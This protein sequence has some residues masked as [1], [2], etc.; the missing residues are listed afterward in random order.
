MTRREDDAKRKAGVAMIKDFP[1]QMFVESS[2][3][4]IEK[5]LCGLSR[6]VSENT[7]Q[8]SL[9]E[10]LKKQLAEDK[11]ERLIALEKEN[12]MLKSKANMTLNLSD[13]EAERLKKFL[14]EHRET[15][16]CKTFH[17]EVHPTGI[18]TFV[19]V[20]CNRCG[21]KECISDPF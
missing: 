17:Y 13:S 21:E 11:G 19:D 20:V 8:K 10:S 6:I 18:A 5:I 3:E 16:S 4:S 15:C 12:F 1:R 9:I 7:R 14:G 2:D